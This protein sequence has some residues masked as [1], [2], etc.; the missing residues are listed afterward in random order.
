VDD[1]SIA[2]LFAPE[3]PVVLP[4]FEPSPLARDETQAGTGHVDVAFAITKYGRAREIEVRGAANVTEADQAD[5][6]SLLKNTRFRP[7][8]TEGEFAEASPVAVRY[9]LPVIGNDQ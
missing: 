1:A 8:L 7:R 6:V 3:Q 9:Y 5:L 4:S 2:Q